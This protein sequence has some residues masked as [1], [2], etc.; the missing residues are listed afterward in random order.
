MLEEKEI[1]AQQP[2][3]QSAEEYAA[4]IKALKESTV[5][6]DEYDKVVADRAVLVKAL[7]GEG[8]IPEGVQE[9]AQKPDVKELRKKFLDAGEQDLTNAEYIK[10]ALELRKAIIDEGGMDPFLP[11]GAKASP[12]PQDIVGATKAAEA[13]QSWLDAATDENGKIDNELF[14]AFMK[15]GISEDSPI[16]TARLKAA[17][18]ARR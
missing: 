8:P 7:S 4:A 1:Q 10:T 5:S 18:K 12:T 13:F 17:N 15:K 16:L 6:K 11:Q 14:N 2:E 9:K 3:I